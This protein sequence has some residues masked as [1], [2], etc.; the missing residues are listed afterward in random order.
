MGR[1]LAVLLLIAGGALGIVL[2]PYSLHLNASDAVQ[3]AP[4]WQMLSSLVDVVFLVAAAVLVIRARPRAAAIFLCGETLLTLGLNAGL[5]ARDGLSRFTHGYGGEQYL[6][7][8]MLALAIRPL[9][10]LL[11]LSSPKEDATAPVPR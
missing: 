2:D 4:L 3:R 9:A 11:L 10:L 1:N 6:T 7:L 8:Y 5:V